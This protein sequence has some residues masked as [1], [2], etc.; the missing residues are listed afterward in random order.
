MHIFFLPIATFLITLVWYAFWIFTAVHVFSVGEPEPREGYEFIT[1]VKWDKTTRYA[2]LYHLFGLLWVNAF[3][4]GGTQFIIGASACIWYFEC[5]SDTKG[6]GTVGRGFWWLFRYHLGSV[7]FGACI[8]AICQMIRIIF[9]YYRRQIQTASRDNKLVKALLCLTG[10]LLWLME[11]C[12]KYITK[13]AYIQIAL[14]NNSFCKSA[15]NAFT[16]LLKHAHRFGLGNS[17][18]FVYMLFGC[19]CIAAC[20]TV[21]SYVFLTE[22]TS[23][24]I[25]EPFAPMVVVACVSVVIGFAFLSIFSFS[26]DAIF[27]AFLLDEELRFAGNDRPE[28]MQEFAAELKNRGKG[29]CEGSCF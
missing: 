24:D 13:N 18:G 28:Y 10:Y 22:Y 27:Q 2:F 15:W 11:N 17:I 19:I 23:L 8:I 12:V 16:L 7:A 20:N 25:T 26:S 29:C 4:I 14:T 9:E 21:I 1:H 5:N 6:R 3:I